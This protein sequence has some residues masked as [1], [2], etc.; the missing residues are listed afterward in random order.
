MYVHIRRKRAASMVLVVAFILALAVIIVAAIAL[1]NLLGGGQQMQR[2]TDAGNLSL[3]RSVLIKVAVP[4]PSSG[5]AVQF[6]GVTDHTAGANGVVN[7]R[8][9]NRLIAQSMIVN[10]NA[11]KIA[12]DGLD[13]GASAHAAQITLTAQNLGKQ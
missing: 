1:I 13:Q 6:N 8:D 7:L 11:H 4:I 9:I 2:A 3:A 10:F 5:D 12:Q